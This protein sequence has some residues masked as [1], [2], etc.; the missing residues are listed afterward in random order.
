MFLATGWS[1]FVQINYCFRINDLAKVLDSWRGQCFLLWLTKNSKPRLFIMLGGKVCS[2]RKQQFP[3]VC[4]LNADII[5]CPSIQR[6]RT[7][8]PGHKPLTVLSLPTKP[9]WSWRLVVVSLWTQHPWTLRPR[10]KRPSCFVL[11]YV[12]GMV[13]TQVCYFMDFGLRKRKKVT[14][15][16]YQERTDKMSKQKFQEICDFSIHE[17]QQMI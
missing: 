2:W 7:N 15:R 12:K 11:C 3:V 16:T 13:W 4:F 14:A 6:P 8:F 9:P 5:E 17:N 10:P 1:H